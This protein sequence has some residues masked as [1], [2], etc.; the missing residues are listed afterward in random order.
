MDGFLGE[1][2]AG[3]GFKNNYATAT[4]GEPTYA[5]YFHPNKRHSF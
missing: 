4:L 1:G 2:L 3:W 5:V